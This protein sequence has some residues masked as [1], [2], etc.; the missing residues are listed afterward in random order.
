MIHLVLQC[1]YLQQRMREVSSNFDTRGLFFGLKFLAVLFGLFAIAY[2][3]GQLVGNRVFGSDTLEQKADEA[4]EQARLHHELI[5]SVKGAIKVL[6]E[7]D[8]WIPRGDD[9]A[10]AIASNVSP[11]TSARAFL[12]ADVVTG[13][14]YIQKQALQTL[15]IAS[16]TKLMTA[17]VAD[18]R[19]ASTAYLRNESNGE[20]YRAS[21]LIYPLFLRSDNAVADSLADAYG[22]FAFLQAMNEKAEVLGMRKT[23]YDDPSGISARNV[24]T[25]ADLYRLAQYIYFKKRPLLDISQE[26]RA[27]ISA[28]SGEVLVMNNQ[29]Q[30]AQDSHF[31]GGKLGF[32]E[33]ALQT[34]VGLFS[35][36]IAGRPRTVVVVVLGSYDWKQDTHT[37]LSWFTNAASPIPQTF[38]KL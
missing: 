26:E 1:S 10:L 25:A 38:T 17:I 29:N 8:E 31:I 12:M 21:D 19:L 15:P 5:A 27:K 4:L 30:F 6:E 36:N 22:R 24:S 28:Q 34:S 20:Y 14:V 13:Q 32:T 23:Y 33:A 37:L 9:P 16:V 3:G 18:E 7:D 11:A 2:G 35:V